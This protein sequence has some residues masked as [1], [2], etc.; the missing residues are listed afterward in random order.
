VT[1]L[2]K[3]TIADQQ[4]IDAIA[5][6]QALTRVSRFL[7]R[8]TTEL[9]LPDFRVL[10]AV[11]SGEARASRVAARLAIGRPTISAAV[12]SLCKRGLLVRAEVDGDQRAASLTLTAE[13]SA[14]RQRVEDSLV[15]ELQ[16]L[17]DRTQDAD[18]V[19]ESLA[20]LGSAIES[21]INERTDA[22]SESLVSATV[23]VGR[24]S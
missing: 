2:S 16:A 18:R 6:V 5:A 21:I 14:V 8:A 12:D 9:S 22:R 3:S 17:C 24:R 7:E 1:E 15:G 20:W 4:S 19:I 10:S 23:Q 11:D 13:G